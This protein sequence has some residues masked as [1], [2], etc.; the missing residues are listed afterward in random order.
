MLEKL[1]VHLRRDNITRDHL[2]ISS[3]NLGADSTLQY[4]TVGDP[5]KDITGFPA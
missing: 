3:A 1:S 5:A 4:W 2:A